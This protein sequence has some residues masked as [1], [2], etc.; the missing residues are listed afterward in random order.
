M[1][2]LAI[3]YFATAKDETER[4]AKRRTEIAARRRDDSELESTDRGL[5]SGENDQPRATSDHEG[6]DTNQRGA[7]T[8]KDAGV[9]PT[10]AECQTVD[11]RQSKTI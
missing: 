8:A 7:G 10:E 5:T 11:R 6:P 9:E 1:R 3:K 2:W 4:A